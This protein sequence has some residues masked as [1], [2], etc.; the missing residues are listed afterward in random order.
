[1][2]ECNNQSDTKYLNSVVVESDKCIT[3]NSQQCAT[4]KKRVTVNN[5]R[6]IYSSHCALL[7]LF[8]LFCL[9]YWRTHCIYFYC[10]KLKFETIEQTYTKGGGGVRSSTQASLKVYIIHTNQM[11]HDF[12]Q[13]W[14]ELKRDI[15]RIVAMAR[16]H[17]QT[18]PPSLHSR[19]QMQ[20]QVFIR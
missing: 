16:R 2:Q 18:T 20:I 7:L 1:M 4:L 10:T 6:T 3:Y 19:G 5:M 17:T 8:T 15:L 11:T 12:S 13:I 9:S 14:H